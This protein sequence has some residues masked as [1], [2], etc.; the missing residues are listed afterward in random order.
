MFSFI[1]NARLQQQ[2]KSVPA[3]VWVAGGIVALFLAI[4]VINFVV[5]LVWALIKFLFIPAVLVGV[6]YL[7][8]RSRK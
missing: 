6:A 4:V 5:G 7:I 1:S 2:A 3:W 8:Y